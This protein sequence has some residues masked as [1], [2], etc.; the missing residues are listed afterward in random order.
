MG[1]V[2]L[3]LEV[4][5]RWVKLAL[6]HSSLTDHIGYYP[7]S[8]VKVGWTILVARLELTS[9][10]PISR[11]IGLISLATIRMVSLACTSNLA[12]A[13]DEPALIRRGAFATFATEGTGFSQHFPGILPH[14]L[15]LGMST[16]VVPGTRLTPRLQLQDPNLP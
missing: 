6:S 12:S 11:R 10:K 16:H 14:L 7:C 8:I 9:R 4:L 5:C 15:T 1:S 13:G 3:D 2:R